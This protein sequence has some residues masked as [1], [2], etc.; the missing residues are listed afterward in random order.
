MTCLA[1]RIIRC[2]LHAYGP[3]PVSV[4]VRAWRQGGCRGRQG[5]AKNVAAPG[6]FACSTVACSTGLHH[7]SSGLAC[8]NATCSQRDNGVVPDKSRPP[9]T[10]R[11]DAEMAVMLC[12]QRRTPVCARHTAAGNATRAAHQQGTPRVKGQRPWRSPPKETH[13]PWFRGQANAWAWREDACRGFE[14]RCEGTCS[15]QTRERESRWA[16]R[17]MISSDTSSPSAPAIRPPNTTMCSPG[18]VGKDTC[19]KTSG[20]AHMQQA[21]ARLPT[22]SSPPLH[23]PR[24]QVASRRRRPTRSLR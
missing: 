8:N 17:V 16:A 5:C 20:A 23:A 14:G 10:T 15:M 3:A 6:A 9:E 4:Y 12:P 19:S 7:R 11:A 2:S 13:P 1:Q 24:P 21:G 18:G 22:A